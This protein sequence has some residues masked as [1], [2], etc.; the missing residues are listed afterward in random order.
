M[1]MLTRKRNDRIK[2]IMRK[3][4][5]YIV[6]YCV[7]NG[8]GTI[9]IG[10]N[11]DFKRSVNMGHINNQ[12][13]VQ[14]SFGDLRQMLSCLCEQEGILY[15][16]QEESYTS[17]SS[18]LDNDPV[19]VYNAEHPYVGKFSGERIHRGLYC[20]AGNVVVNADVNGAA[21][22]IRKSKQNFRKE[23]LY[24]GLLASPRRIRVS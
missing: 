7:D 10:Y 14:I 17:K 11:P 19:P 22:I 15:V 13:F 21:N 6:N 4:A 9:V 20:S 18:F 1:D 23:G 8:I 12:N 2:D 16:E 24:S 5:R 3:T